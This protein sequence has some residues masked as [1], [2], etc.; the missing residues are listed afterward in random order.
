MFFLS[1]GPVCAIQLQ[2]TNESVAVAEIIECASGSDDD[3][4]EEL[5]NRLMFLG[6]S[7][8]MIWPMR[9]AIPSLIPP[10]LGWMMMMMCLENACTKQ[11]KQG[12][13]CRSEFIFTTRLV[14]NVWHSGLPNGMTGYKFAW[15]GKWLCMYYNNHCLVEETGC[16]YKIYWT[17]LCFLV[18]NYNVVL[19]CLQ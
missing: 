12:R 18:R 4:D 13:C 11:E 7:T 14:W 3:D 15:V 17:N 2:R 5:C 10:W 19:Q 1:W 16:F 8:E 6:I 9:I